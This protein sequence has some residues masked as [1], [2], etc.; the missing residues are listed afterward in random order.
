MKQ[1]PGEAHLTLEE[2]QDMAKNN[3][4]KSFMTNLSRYVR[5][6]TG[7]SAYW[8]KVQQDLKTI[9]S[10]K[11]PPAVLFHVLL[12]RHALARITQTFLF[13]C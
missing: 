1:N 2:L 7:S 10:Y 11:G 12:S 5:H 8:Q 4:S 9:I 3:T 13:T 6:I